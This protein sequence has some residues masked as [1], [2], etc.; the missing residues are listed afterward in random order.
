VFSG[1][2]DHQNPIG[3][4]KIRLVKFENVNRS[5]NSEEIPFSAQG[6]NS[7]KNGMDDR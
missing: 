2:K 3:K 7:Y 1:K 4:S 6:K 5:R